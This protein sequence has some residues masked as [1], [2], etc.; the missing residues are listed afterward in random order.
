MSLG[1]RQGHLTPTD[2]DLREGFQEEKPD[3]TGKDKQGSA[4]RG[5]WCSFW[6]IK[7]VPGCRESGSKDLAKRE[8]P[9]HIQGTLPE[10]QI[11][12]FLP[13]RDSVAECFQQSERVK[14]EARNS[15]SGRQ[16]GRHW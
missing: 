8:E 2:R 11:L 3:L 13:P 1:C 14:K 6:C 15:L 10:C 7:K 12:T 16:E 5:V 9:Q 4:R